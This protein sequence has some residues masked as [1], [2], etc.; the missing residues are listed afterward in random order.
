MTLHAGAAGAPGAGR[1]GESV[2]GP[3]RRAVKGESIV[4]RRGAVGAAWVWMACGMLA[5][6]ASPAAPSAPVPATPMPELVLQLGHDNDVASVAFSPDG[7]IVASGGTD[8]VTILWNPAT[9]DVLRRLTGHPDS[10]SSVAFSPDGK[11]LACGGGEVRLWDVRTGRVR[12]VLAGEDAGGWGLAFTPDWR[13]IGASGRNGE[14]RLW[15]V[16]TGKPRLRLARRGERITFS[17]DGRT[18]ASAWENGVNVWDSRTGRLLRTWKHALPVEALAFSPD[19]SRIAIGCGRHDKEGEL[20]LRRSRTGTRLLATRTRWVN[21]VAFSPDGRV[22]TT[23]NRD[24]EVRLWSVPGGQLLR[25]LR[26]SGEQPWTGVAISPDGRR[27]ASSGDG[28][29]LWNARTGGV[30]R[31]LTGRGQAGRPWIEAVAFSPDGAILATGGGWYAAESRPGGAAIWDARTGALRKGL[32]GEEYGHETRALAFSPDGRWMVSGGGEIRL[33]DAGT[34]SLHRMLGGRT[35]GR[36]V[37]ISPDGRW[38]AAGAWGVELPAAVRVWETE[39][40]TEGARLPTWDPVVF[41]P[42][43]K[44]I[45]TPGPPD[46]LSVWDLPVRAASAT[47]ARALRPQRG[48]VSCLAVD[49]GGSIVASGNLEGRI[50]LWDLPSGKTTRTLSGGDREVR[51]LGFSGDGRTLAAATARGMVELW[52]VRSGVLRAR[53]QGHSDEVASVAFAPSGMK[54]ASASWDGTARVWDTVRARLLVTLVVLPSKKWSEAPV[55][56]IAYT[57]EGYYN[58][59]PGA[60]G[61]IRWRVGEQLRPA[62][63]YEA[64]FHR[65][66]QVR[67][68]LRAE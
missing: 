63:A 12:R 55:D 36:S 16:N 65:R 11:T 25:T 34:W 51:S 44:E 29:T 58:G 1:P 20:V 54:L 30:L 4:H 13:R 61:F 62:A 57:P 38:V 22:V 6:P 41:T 2:A 53:L 26:E 50:Q 19:G 52:D 47:P 60:A 27:I 40:G 49:P 67:A 28:V 3:G 21:S 23:S 64:A 48:S 18:A 9:G 39:T 46:A 7:R 5:R 32:P 42:D 68:A 31:R 37:V 43:G 24:G 8:R 59:S 56:W 33:W 15:D 45:I 66:E 14:V 17:P 10:V 35:Y